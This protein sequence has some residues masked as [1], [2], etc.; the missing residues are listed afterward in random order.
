MLVDA[1][2]RRGKH[3]L[4]WLWIERVVVVGAGGHLGKRRGDRERERGRK[5]GGERRGKLLKYR[6]SRLVRGGRTAKKKR[7]R[8]RQV[9]LEEDRSKSETTVVEMLVMSQKV[10]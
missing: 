8:V 2:G 3:S 4:R 5:G 1:H 7:K 10:E 6:R 9:E